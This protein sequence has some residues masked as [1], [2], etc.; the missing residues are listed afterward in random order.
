[1]LLLLTLLLHSIQ[2]G[3]EVM[4]NSMQVHQLY[5]PIKIERQR[6]RTLQLCGC[7]MLFCTFLHLC[8]AHR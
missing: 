7:I 2:S 3:G 8:E 4:L 5:L 6:E 1:M